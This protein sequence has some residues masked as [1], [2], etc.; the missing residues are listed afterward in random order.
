M[1]Y[2]STM[3][4]KNKKIQ[5]RIK[6][7]LKDQLWEYAIRT[8]MTFNA[9]CVLCMKAGLD[10]LKVALSTEFSKVMEQLSKEYEGTK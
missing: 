3:A 1:E 8:D 10:V 9:M 2:T 6:P 4:T 5:L 7:E